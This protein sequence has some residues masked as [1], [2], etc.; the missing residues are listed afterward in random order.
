M[1]S[2]ILDSS[3]H[4]YLLSVIFLVSLVL[5]SHL[6]L[7]KLGETSWIKA[8][9]DSGSKWRH[10]Q[11]VKTRCIVHLHSQSMSCSLWEMVIGLS[12]L[13]PKMF[14]ISEYNRH[15][16]CCY[17]LA[18]SQ[19]EWKANIHIV[20]HFHMKRIPQQMEKDWQREV[21]VTNN[22]VMW[23]WMLDLVSEVNHPA[24]LCQ[25]D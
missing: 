8:E 14:W 20:L 17:K 19:M 9:T 13:V 6:M 10:V 11:D 25:T 3:Y 21:Q 22:S 16:E 24:S 18:H 5:M 4:T 15:Q 23:M 7:Y 1:C 12:E 2:V